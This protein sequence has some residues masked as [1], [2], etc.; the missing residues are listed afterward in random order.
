MTYSKS[1]QGI[2]RVT[3]TDYTTLHFLAHDERD[4]RTQALRFIIR[5]RLDVSILDITQ[6]K[7][8][9]IDDIPF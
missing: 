4:A 3:L 1:S 5:S 6:R 7:F 9:D 8:I 2:Y